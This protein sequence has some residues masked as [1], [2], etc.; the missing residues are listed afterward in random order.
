[1]DRICIVCGCSSEEKSFHPT[2]NICRE[3]Y[4]ERCKQSRLKHKDKHKAKNR[5]RMM[6]K[7]LSNNRDLEG[8]GNNKNRDFLLY[9][10]TD[11][12]RSKNGEGRF[13]ITRVDHS[14]QVQDIT[15]FHIRKRHKR[16]S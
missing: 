3:D 10:N 16:A 4:N 15:S 13:N 6:V 14:K 2:R 1:M 5:K 7:R 12:E 8:W 9:Y 11:S